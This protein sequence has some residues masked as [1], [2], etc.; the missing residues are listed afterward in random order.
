CRASL[1]TNHWTD[2]RSGSRDTHRASRW[3]SLRT[4][5]YFPRQNEC[6]GNPLINTTFNEENTLALAFLPASILRASLRDTCG[7]SCWDS[8][9][10]VFRDSL[11]NI[12]WG[13]HYTNLRL[14][15]WI[16]PPSP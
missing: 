8:Q 4:A 5:V 12:R 9:R 7:T 2:L 16:D 11:W 14:G 6:H 3:A 10:V 13:N 15:L 1:R